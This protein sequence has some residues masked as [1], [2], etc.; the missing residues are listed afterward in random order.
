VEHNAQHLVAA[1]GRLLFAV[2]VGIGHMSEDS[3]D[4]P[5]P[6][7]WMADINDK[8]DEFFLWVGRCITVWASVDE[9]LFAIFHE[10]I[11]PKLQSAIIYYRTNTIGA[12]LAL[13]AAIV[14]SYFPKEQKNGGKDH[15]TVIAWRKVK[16]DFDDQLGTRNRL[17]HHP[18][19]ISIY[20]R[21]DNIDWVEGP[22]EDSFATYE[23]HMSQGEEMKEGKAPEPLNILDLRD[24]YAKVTLVRNAL[25]LFR[26]NELPKRPR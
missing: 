4:A 16:K 14:E 22:P 7:G 11:G 18:V 23:L 5:K 20:S 6:K 12:R 24:H 10:C 2:F 15:E 9:E 13:T 3:T 26:Q 8:H 1:F 25:D 19:H 21:G 17:A